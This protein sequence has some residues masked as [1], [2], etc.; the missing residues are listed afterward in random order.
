MTI[1]S[2]FRLRVWLSRALLVL[3]IILGGL[4]FLNFSGAGK[5]ATSFI[6]TPESRIRVFDGRT[7]VL[8]LGKGGEGHAGADLTDTIIFASFSHEDRGLTL[9]SVP[10]DIW[11]PEIRAKLNS[12]YFWGT[13]KPEWGGITLTKSLVEE[14][15]GQPVHYAVVLDF[16]GFK[17]AIDVLGGIEVDVERSF[18]D[19]KYPI[20][21]KE[22]DDCGKDDPEFKCRYETVTFIQGRQYMDGATAL[23]FVR[24]RKAEGEEG[25][26]LARAARQQKVITAVV[27][28]VLNPRTLLNPRKIFAIWRVAKEAVETDL[29]ASSGAVL[30]RKVLDD[31]G[32]STSMVLPEELLEVPTP[33]EKYDDQ[34]V[35]IPRRG[36]APGGK[37][38]WTEVRHWTEDRLP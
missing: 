25:T 31:R 11:V 38:D 34:S 30:A 23:K 15:L 36:T 26:D 35:F 19:A 17:R 24:S 4:L 7:N 8:V 28:R 12:A 32:N 14:I 10:R 16:E 5:S 37:F 9:I 27:N 3:G 18:V 33:S 1:M 21:G 29:D 13:Q 6:F 22:D 2:H 20:E